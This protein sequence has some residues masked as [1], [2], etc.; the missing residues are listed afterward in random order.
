MDGAKQLGLV[1]V[2]GGAHLA[3][4]WLA[5]EL[6]RAPLPGGFKRVTLGAQPGFQVRLP[7]YH[8]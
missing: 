4:L 6:V 1:L 2:E 8:P 5:I 7:S 3:Q